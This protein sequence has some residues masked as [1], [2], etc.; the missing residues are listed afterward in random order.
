MET[1]RSDK[2]LSSIVTFFSRYSHSWEGPGSPGVPDDGR[3]SSATVGQVLGGSGGPHSGHLAG[4]F[5]SPCLILELRKCVPSG[6]PLSAEKCPVH[7]LLRCSPGIHHLGAPT[8]P[9]ARGQESILTVC[10]HR[11]WPPR[12][13]FLKARI[14]PGSLAIFFSLHP[15]LLSLLHV[16]SS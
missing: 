8:G 6:S 12:P 7:L 1:G 11:S 15:P 10:G 14:A 4:L 16:S 9:C 3:V 2:G 13:S 5:L